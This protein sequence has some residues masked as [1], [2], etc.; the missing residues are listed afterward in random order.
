MDLQL[1]V[2]TWNYACV[3]N[4]VRL[5]DA[6]TETKENGFGVELWLNWQPEPEV[7]A[8]KNWNAVKEWLAGV[9][10]L[11]VHSKC[12]NKDWASITKEIE[13]SSFLEADLLVVHVLNFGVVEAENKLE[14]D[15]NYFYRVLEFAESHNVTLALENGFFSSLQRFS[16]LAGPERLKMCLDIGHANTSQAGMETGA[17]EAFIGKFADR[18]V[19][20][21][22]HD[23]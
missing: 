20:L 15:E 3:D 13:L 5:K 14:I 11:S 19:H 10:R 17:L 12:D 2:S 16:A 18:I 9:K 8:R 7:F 22:L 23:N 1:N 4:N 21:H 6:V